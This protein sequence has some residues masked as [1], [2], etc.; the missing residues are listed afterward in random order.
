MFVLLGIREGCR[1]QQS[2]ADRITCIS[3]PN[4]I[5]GP[6]K[7]GPPSPWCFLCL[8]VYLS[9]CVLSLDNV[10]GVCR[11][12]HLRGRSCHSLIQERPGAEPFSARVEILTPFSVSLLR[13]HLH[14]CS[15]LG[16]GPDCPSLQAGAA[17]LVLGGSLCGSPCPAAAFLGVSW[18][19]GLALQAGLRPLRSPSESSE[20]S[21]DRGGA[22]TLD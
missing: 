21:V 18:S 22:A 3:F 19:W 12:R 6:M 16:F 11:H 8:S 13:I 9:S 1:N 20:S 15:P 17:E 14:L 7:A 10:P 2:L 5:S 4:W